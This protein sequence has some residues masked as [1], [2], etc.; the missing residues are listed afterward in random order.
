MRCF[1]DLNVAVETL[2]SAG[3]SVSRNR[4]EGNQ[5][6]TIREARNRMDGAKLR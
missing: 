1:Y 3:G 2:G 6:R 4:G 5:I